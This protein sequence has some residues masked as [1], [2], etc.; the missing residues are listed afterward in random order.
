[1]SS[2]WGLRQRVEER[3][4]VNHMSP[5]LP[6][7]TATQLVRALHKD[8]WY[9]DHQR[10]SHLYLLHPTKS[11]RVAVPMH[12]G[13][14]IKTGLLASILKDADLSVDEFRRLL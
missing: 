5:K 12:A 8:G 13:K 9:D 4:P 11:N 3:R 6:R 14:T 7:I 1:M 2:E 10:G